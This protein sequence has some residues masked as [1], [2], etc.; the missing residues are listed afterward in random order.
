MMFTNMDWKNN[1]LIFMKIIGEKY[2]DWH[3]ELWEKHGLK[4]EDAKAL[5]KEYEKK[6]L[7]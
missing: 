3:P 2:D 1:M 4:R 7:K 6:F 5:V